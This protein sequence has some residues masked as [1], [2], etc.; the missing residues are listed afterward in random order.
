[1]HQ[2][3]ITSDSLYRSPCTTCFYLLRGES[4]A[5][6]VDD[7]SYFASIRSKAVEGDSK[8]KGHGAGAE[9]GGESNSH[10][11]LPNVRVGHSGVQAAG[12]LGYR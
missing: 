6:Q 4:V 12:N 11:V 9:G 1:M 3:H 2:R 5:I 8:L 7:V 10:P